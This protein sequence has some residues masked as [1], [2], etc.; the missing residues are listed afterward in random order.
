MG[1]DV[2]VKL[3][4]KKMVERVSVVSTIGLADGVQVSVSVPTTEGILDSVVPGVVDEGE[5]RKVNV[6]DDEESNGA[7]KVELGLGDNKDGDE[8]PSSPHKA[9][10]NVHVS[11]TSSA[12]HEI[13]RQGSKGAPF[14]IFK[15]LH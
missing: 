5:V 7:N 4:T 9:L 13:R 14:N 10:A 2:D 8:T 3:N 12:E 1:I 11:L 15:H 6:L